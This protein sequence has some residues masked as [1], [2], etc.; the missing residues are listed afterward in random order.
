[1]EE[2]IKFICNENELNNLP[3]NIKY[4]EFNFGFNKKVDN[5]PNITLVI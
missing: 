3:S 4:L 5:L 1:M 2:E